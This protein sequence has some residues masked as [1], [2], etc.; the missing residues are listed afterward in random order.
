[1]LE[2]EQMARTVAKRLHTALPDA[3]FSPG[4][5]SVWLRFVRYVPAEGGGQLEETVG[6]TSRLF[7]TA[8]STAEL[9]EQMAQNVILKVYGEEIQTVKDLPNLVVR[10]DGRRAKLP[11]PG[12][13]PLDQAGQ[14]LLKVTVFRYQPGLWEQ[15]FGRGRE[16]EGE[17]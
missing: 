8:L 17:A 12:A 14:I 3:G 11:M 9:Y 6:V 4:R 13:P 16:G 1:M 15:L 5:F 2:L 10:V 7:L